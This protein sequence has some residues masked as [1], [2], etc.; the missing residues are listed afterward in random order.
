M[1]G[2]IAEMHGRSNA[3]GLHEPLACVATSGSHHALISAEAFLTYYYGSA[4]KASPITDPLNTV[5]VRDR[6][7]LVQS[8]EKMTV[9]DLTFRMLTPH[10]IG[11]AMAFPQTYVVKGNGRE[12]VKQYGN[13]V[14]PPAMKMLMERC[15]ATFE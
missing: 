14:T 5:T 13:A 10:E 8:L 11:K 12:Q 1:P 15:M 6:V 9:D 3:G 2:F 4:E 7:G